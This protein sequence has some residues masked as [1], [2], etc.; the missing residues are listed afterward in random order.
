MEEEKVFSMLPLISA[1]DE[2]DNV[3]TFKFETNSLT[4]VAGRK[5]IRK[6]T[7]YLVLPHWCRVLELH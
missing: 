6:P 7:F 1:H 3:G 4:W 2:V 5:L